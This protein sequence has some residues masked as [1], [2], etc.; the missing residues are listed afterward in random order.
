MRN[1][2]LAY[3]EHLSDGDLDLL[4][5]TAGP[6]TRP[7]T[8]RR[9]LAHHPDTVDDLLATPRLYE[10]LFG[11]AAP[12]GSR[13]SA[14]LT[15]G[16]LVNRSARDLHAL[17]YVP[18][19]TG[20]GQRLPVF[21]VDA[22]RDFVDHGA[23]RFFLVELLTSFTRVASGS[24]WVRTRRGHRRRR[25]SELDP[26]YLSE[27]VEAMPR[28]LRPAGYR[29]LGDVAL[30]LAGVFP[31]HT[32]RRALREA[33]RDRLARSAGLSPAAALGPADLSFYEMAASAW[34]RR[35]AEEARAAVGAGPAELEDVAE[36][37]PQARRVLNFLTDRYLFR[38]DTGLAGPAGG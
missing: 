18:E 13:P 30:F 27:M 21:D 6:G 8:L 26:V 22:L 28:S 7:A 29:R 11:P 16:V 31:D 20:A 5:R 19:W 2:A 24:T 32:A 25:F 3:L 23:R 36:R 15:F 10:E 12:L 35:A 9:E 34:Y 33:D 38:L 14:F 37:I 17:T 4:A 1:Y